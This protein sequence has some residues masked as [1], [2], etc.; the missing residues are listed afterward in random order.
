M[1]PFV[2]KM[3][4]T[5]EGKTYESFDLSGLDDL[6]GEQYAS[7]LQETAKVEGETLVPE[8]TITFV[9]LTTAKVTGLP[10]DLFCTL[11]AKDA[12]RLRYEVGKYFLAED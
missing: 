9:Y 3:P 8:K 10:Y 6:T 4:I 12:A 5:F 7:L 1:E 2:L 11:K